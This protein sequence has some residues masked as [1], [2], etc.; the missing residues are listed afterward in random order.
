[1]GYDFKENIGYLSVNGIV[2]LYVV[3]EIV[4]ELVGWW[5]EEIQGKRFE[6]VLELVQIDETN[7]VDACLK[8][9]S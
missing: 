6:F 3:G 2:R 4:F 9:Q 5:K 1:M 7:S 8:I